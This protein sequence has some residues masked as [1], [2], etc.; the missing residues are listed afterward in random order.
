[1]IDDIPSRI[2]ILDTAGQEEFI[3]LRHQWIR[4]GGAFLLVYSCLS[5]ASF[6]EIERLKKEVDMVK[7][8]NNTPIILIANKCDMISEAQ[9]SREQGLELS[10]KLQVSFIETSAKTGMNVENA[11]F[12][13]IRKFRSFQELSRTTKKKKRT[14]CKLL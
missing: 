8:C 14:K 1:M 11:F 4:E 13:L 2:E 3:A 9:V 12:D 7:E 5:L 10:N 6:N